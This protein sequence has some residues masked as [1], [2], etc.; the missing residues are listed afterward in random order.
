M[1]LGF[2]AS[3]GPQRTYPSRVPDDDFLI[4]C[5]KKGRFFRV[6]AGLLRALELESCLGFEDFFCLLEKA[7]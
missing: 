2:A 6:Q 3:V 5:P 4:Q 1:G 7:L